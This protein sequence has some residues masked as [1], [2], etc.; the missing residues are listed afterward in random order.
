MPAYIELTRGYKAIVDE[1]FAEE[2]R[3]R[4]WHIRRQS[5]SSVIYAGGNIKRDGRFCTLLMHLEVLR[6]AGV[7]PGKHTDHRDGDGLNNQL[8]NLRVA[9]ESQN[10][11]NRR[12]NK[13]STCGYKGVCYRPNGTW[14]ARIQVGKRRIALGNFGTA[15]EAA[16]AYNRAAVQYSGEFA[17]LNR[18]N[19]A[20]A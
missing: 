19:E 9:T 3:K 13:N 20:S 16:E 17:R 6:L 10:G 15:E 8:D 14:R 4:K 11:R 12:V 5:K 18:I 2:L 7:K 1:R